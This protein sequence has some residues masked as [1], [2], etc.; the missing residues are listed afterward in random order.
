MRLVVIGASGLLGREVVRAAVRRGHAVLAVGSTRPPSVPP[1]VETAR[2][3][4]GD[5]AGAERLVLDRFPDGVINAAALSDVGVCER[6]LGLA[7]QA[8][9][10]LPGRLAQLANHVGARFIHLSTDMVFDGTRGPYRSTDTP[11]PL[12]V[13]ARTKLE[14]EEAVMAAGRHGA[15][16]VRSTPIL[17]N[18][19]GGDRTPHERLFL[20]WKAGK[21]ARLFTE[22]VRQPVSS[23]NLAEVCVELAE[24][25]NLSGIFHWGGSEAVTRLELGERIARRFGLDPAGLVQGVS[26]ADVPGLPARPR[27]L[28]VELHPLAGKLRTRPQRLDEILDGLEVPRGCED[29][30]RERTGG[31][32]VRRLEQ[33]LDF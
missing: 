23:P 6:E 19:P 29:W 7:R 2:L 1:G 9:I 5:L 30:W 28:S 31:D 13:Y 32:V 26:Y 22:E 18:T 21:V 20:D 14:G 8:N 25:G 15:C 3:A 11:A 24:R 12:N 4:A 10:E 17:G 16:V 33:G 27:D